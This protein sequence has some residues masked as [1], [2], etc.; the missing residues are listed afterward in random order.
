MTQGIIKATSQELKGAHRWQWHVGET[1]KNVIHEH[2]GDPEQN[3]L[4]V[5]R[6]GIK[7]KWCKV[8][9]HQEDGGKENKLGR[10]QTRN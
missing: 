7:D 1:V 5:G 3:E 8:T 10:A 2:V 9:A 4:P 6:E